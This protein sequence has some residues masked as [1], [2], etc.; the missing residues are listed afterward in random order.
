MLPQPP[1]Q[2]T[3]LRLHVAVL[4]RT[5]HMDR[6]RRQIV[7]AAQFQVIRIVGSRTPRHLFQFVRG[8]AGVVGPQMRRT[9]AQ[10][11]QGR[12]QAGHQTQE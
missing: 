11:P 7:M 10:L 1:F 3:V 4:V 2:M 9:F 8:G 5:A 12:L 6:D